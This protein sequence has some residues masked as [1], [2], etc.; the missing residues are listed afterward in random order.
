M[1]P[2]DPLGTIRQSHYNSLI[3]CKL[4]LTLPQAANVIDRRVLVALV[5]AA[6]LMPMVVLILLGVGKLLTALGDATGAVWLDRIALV[7]SI[8]W[9]VDL[10]LMLIVVAINSLD[11]SE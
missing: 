7:G 11:R 1:V 6:M 9:A 5:T 4:A 8:L 10:L 2:D 3:P